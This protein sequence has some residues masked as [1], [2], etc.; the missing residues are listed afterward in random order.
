MSNIFIT[1]EVRTTRLH[2]ANR[3]NL[4]KYLKEIERRASRGK[5]YHRPA[6]G[7]REFAADFEWVPDVKEALE[8]RAAEVRAE[9]EDKDW[10]KTW[11]EEDL[12]LMLYDV[13]DVDQREDGFRWLTDEELTDII[14]KQKLSTTKSPKRK[15]NATS[16]NAPKYFE[17]TAIVPRA[18][19]FH[20]RIKDSQMDCHPN[21]IK[22]IPE[23]RKEV[24]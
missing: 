11:A 20:A 21:R 17:G 13:F 6:F 14:S 5:C 3:F 22:I 9:K 8:Q 12:G 10:R 15:S 24:R 4:Q 19:F 23:T 18:S 7:C 2:D 16:D 1:A